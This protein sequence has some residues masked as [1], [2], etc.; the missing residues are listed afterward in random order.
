MVRTRLAPAVLPGITEIGDHRR[1]A[2]GRGAAQHVDTDEKLHQMVVGG[3]GGRLDDENVLAANVLM[4]L[5]EDLHVG[6]APYAGARQR[7][8]EIGGNRF[9][10]GTVAVAHQD[11]HGIGL[12]PY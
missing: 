3:I 2:L 4:D 8:I 1:D 11:L 9:G 10:E 12:R 5:D 6:E 7:K